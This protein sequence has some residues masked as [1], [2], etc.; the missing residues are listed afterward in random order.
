MA[1]GS[2]LLDGTKRRNLLGSA[3]RIIKNCETMNKNTFPLSQ[4]IANKFQEQAQVQLKAIDSDEENSVILT[5]KSTF[6]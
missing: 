4:M 5:M 3:K 1:L 6:W 2:H